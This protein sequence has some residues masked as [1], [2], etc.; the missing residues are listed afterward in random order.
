M[1]VLIFQRDERVRVRNAG[2]VNFI[3]LLG[4]CFYECYKPVEIF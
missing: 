3:L 1:K 4:S 2:D